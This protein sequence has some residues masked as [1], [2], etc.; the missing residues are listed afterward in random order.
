M[1]HKWESRRAC[2][3]HLPEWE[4]GKSIALHLVPVQEKGW[5]RTPN[6]PVQGRDP[7][8]QRSEDGPSLPVKGKDPSQ[9]REEGTFHL[10]KD[11]IQQ[12]SWS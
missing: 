12:T 7:I 5:S 11:P 8:Q 3:P 2:T 1:D 10:Q 4:M 9:Q 6:L